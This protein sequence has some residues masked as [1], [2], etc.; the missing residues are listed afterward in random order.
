MVDHVNALRAVCRAAASVPDRGVAYD[1]LLLG[2]ARWVPYIG[3]WTGETRDE[4]STEQVIQR[5]DGA[6]IGYLRETVVDRDEHGV[7]WRCPPSSVGVGR[8][9]FKVIHPRRQRHA[10]RRLLCQVCAQPAD[11]DE[12]GVLWLLNDYRHDWPGWPERMANTQPPLC[13]PCARASVQLCPSLRRGWVAVRSRR[14]P[15]V[16]VAGDIYRPAFPRPARVKGDVVGYDN[17]LVLWVKASQLVRELHGCTI[18][19]PGELS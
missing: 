11:W 1:P 13:L 10:M 2:G 6:G 8:P 4:D 12:R 17:P 14:H 7:L 16:G 18:L 5:P 15:I 9:L 19:N 3:S